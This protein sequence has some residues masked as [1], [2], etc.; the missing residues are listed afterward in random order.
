MQPQMNYFALAV[1]LARAEAVKTLAKP[2]RRQETCNC[3]AYSFPHRKGSKNCA[4][5]EAA[6][7]EPQECYHC[8]GTGEGSHDGARCRNCRGSGVLRGNDRFEC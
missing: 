8:R 5:L 6:L 1:T 4:E 7:N 3:E 2:K